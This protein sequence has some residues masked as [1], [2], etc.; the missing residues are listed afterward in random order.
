MK[1]LPFSS[2]IGRVAATLTLAG[3]AGATALA[4]TPGTFG[5][6]TSTATNQGNT[7]TAG[8][9]KIGDSVTGTVSALN[10][11]GSGEYTAANLEPGKSVSSTV[12]ISNT[13]SLPE[14][15]TLALAN[16]SENF[17]NASDVLVTVTDSEGDTVLNAVPLADSQ[18]AVT[19]PTSAPNNVWDGTAGTAHS[20][21]YT[22]TVAMPSSD[23]NGDQ[24]ATG[25]FDLDWAGTQA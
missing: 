16:V 10:L 3:A 22:V 25:S 20:D 11:T 6:F 9:V 18:S 17:T 21:V 23:G 7:V 15:I 19:L 12:K 2:R 8:T 14:T 5:G 13:G 1:I 4:V 24:S